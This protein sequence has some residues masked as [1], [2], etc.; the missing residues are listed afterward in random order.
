MKKKLIGYCVETRHYFKFKS[1]W[2]ISGWEPHWNYKIYR[3]KR[4]AQ[5]AIDSFVSTAKQYRIKPLY[6]LSTDEEEFI[7]VMKYALRWRILGDNNP[8]TTYSVH[9]SYQEANDKLQEHLND[10]KFE[11]EIEEIKL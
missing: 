8:W 1:G 4:T 10:T 2:S 5:E 3:D 9:N 6:Q 11:F 7:P